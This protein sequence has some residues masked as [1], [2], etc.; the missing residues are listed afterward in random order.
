MI[1]TLRDAPVAKGSKSEARKTR[2]LETAGIHILS[3]GLLVTVLP[4]TLK[5]TPM[6]QA[7]GKLL[8][9]GLLLLA[10]GAALLFAA[11]KMRSP[12]LPA[13]SGNG[14]VGSVGSKEPKLQP[15]GGARR[16][17]WSPQRRRSPPKGWPRPSPTCGLI[18]G[19]RPCST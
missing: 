18:V 15:S 3:I 4:F 10:G 16:Q 7:F 19:A 5:A 6:A 11:Y 14:D 13:P 2:K 8:P 17:Q 1:P 9:L 12:S